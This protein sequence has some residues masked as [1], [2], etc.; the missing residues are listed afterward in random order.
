LIE[1]GLYAETI[2]FWLRGESK[3]PKNVHLGVVLSRPDRALSRP[4]R[5]LVAPHSTVETESQVW[6]TFLL[7]VPGVAFTLSVGRLISA[8]TR[9]NC[10]HENSNH[11]VFVSD[12]VTDAVWEKL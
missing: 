8:E 2:R 7:H 5:A 9:T 4:D 12:E 10:F 3:F 1:L 11:P 6:R